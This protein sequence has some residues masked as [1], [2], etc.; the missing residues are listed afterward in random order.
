MNQQRTHLPPAAPGV[1]TWAS[2]LLSTALACAPEL[3]R[4]D[5]AAPGSATTALT[6][7]ATAS[8]STLDSPPT[9]AVG[10]PTPPQGPAAYDLTYGRLHDVPV[11]S[12]YKTTKTIGGSHSFSAKV[13]CTASAGDLTPDPALLVVVKGTD[14][15]PARTLFNAEALCLSGCTTPPLSAW[16]FAGP[17]TT[18][19]TYELYAFSQKR[20]TAPCDIFFNATGS[21][22][23]WTKINGAPVELGGTLVRVGALSSAND[24]LEVQT[25]SDG[26]DVNE[27]TKMLFFDLGLAPSNCRAT[28]YAQCAGVN[29]PVQALDRSGTDLDPR[30]Q[31][32]T[33]CGRGCPWEGTEN[34]VLL[35]KEATSWTA[36]E[37]V[38]TR[39]DLVKGPLEQELGA[40]LTPPGAW[41][42]TPLALPRGTYLTYAYAQIADPVGS[43]AQ[44]P[45]PVDGLPNVCQ[46]FDPSSGNEVTPT[47]ELYLRGRLNQDN[48]LSLKLGKLV[49]MTWVTISERQI[50]RGAFGGAGTDGWERF[51]MPLD[52]SLHPD[53]T[54][55][56]LLATPAGGAGVTLYPTW[57]AVRNPDA[58]EVKL[59]TYNQMGDD[60]DTQAHFD[61]KFKN[62]A[63][64]FACRGQIDRANLRVVE[65]LDQARFQWDADVVAMQEVP[66]EPTWDPGCGGAGTSYYPRLFR[67]VAEGAGSSRW[68]YAFDWDEQ[69]WGCSFYGVHDPGEQ[70]TFVRDS[71]NP[72]DGMLFRSSATLYAGCDSSTGGSAA[73]G[74]PSPYRGGPQPGSCHVNTCVNCETANVDVETYSLPARIAAQRG[75]GTAGFT[76]SADRPIAVFNYHPWHKGRANRRATLDDLIGHVKRLLLEQPDAFNRA[77]HVFGVTD[78]PKYA[79]NRFILVGDFNL[80]GHSC[81][82]HYA[83]L[84]RLREEFGYALDVSLAVDGSGAKQLGQHDL[85]TGTTELAHFP[86]G[87]VPNALSL[88]PHGV[89]L[90]ALRYIY[91]GSPEQEVGSWDDWNPEGPRHVGDNDDVLPAPDGFAH[92]PWWS[93]TYRGTTSANNGGSTRLD[94]IMLVGKGW[95]YDDPVQAYRVLWDSHVSIAAMGQT[96]NPASGTPHADCVEQ[97]DDG[98]AGAGGSGSCLDGGRASYRPRFDLNG[99]A[100]PPVAG[101][102]ALHS[103]H[104]PVG[105]R[106]RVWNR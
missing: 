103:D 98:A 73:I 6:T 61:N 21:A 20:S 51:T 57:Y 43:T 8:R 28:P 102:P 81:G 24:F 1:I 69:W 71:W 23:S 59:V 47:G 44:T 36:N 90:T 88:L 84:R 5:E 34:Y 86:S 78:Q 27:N 7:P 13:S 87:V 80:S 29:A 30:V 2:L 41:E 104:K 26:T 37:G 52:T 82:E 65:N 70:V 39:V 14:G 35:G 15:S 92:Y 18:T 96:P 62:A 100:T 31:P 66:R 101:A 38:E 42:P 79:G 16:V 45:N 97:W 77:P 4:G 10:S 93:R 89:R 55:F 64:L 106:L 63:D 83:L 56:T 67:E 32:A 68:A 60:P 99:S 50:S 22:S 74:E 48:V 95:A 40:A 53:A 75:I 3:G 94:A 72:D 58:T 46:D 17:R 12:F 11:S 54:Q 105:V 25:P 9:F 19:T 91:G 49:G 76:P 33:A 85:G